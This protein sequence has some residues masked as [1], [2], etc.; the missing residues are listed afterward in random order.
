MARVGRVAGGNEVA[1]H[2]PHRRTNRRPGGDQTGPASADA[3]GTV[4]RSRTMS[5]MIVVA[6]EALIDLLIHP[7][8]RLAAV[9]GGAPFNTARTIARLGGAV[10]F[11][12]RLSSDR[13]GGVL[14]ERLASD[15]VDLSLAG[16]TDAP[17]TLAVAEL[18]GDGAA[19]YRFHTAETSAPGLTRETVRSAL[20]ARPAAFHLGTLGLVLEPMASALAAG[21]TGLG[22]ET[23]VMLDPNCRPAVIDRRD[24][25]LERLDAVLGRADVVKVSLEDLAYLAPGEAVSTAARALLER[26]PS[27]VLL[28]DGSRGVSIVTRGGAVAVPVP[29]VRV[30]DT[31]GAGDAFG[32]GFLARWIERGLGRSELAD[33]A[34]VRE[35]V[36]RAIE[37]ASLTCRRPGA[38]PPLRVEVDWPPA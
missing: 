11:L 12:G 9:P 31:V 3:T 10:A 28:T 1:H 33:E 37:V 21:V 14:R 32:G 35:A 23:L 22:D 29:A 2:E 7:D 36:T 16:T 27:V 18:D 13:F 25:Y 4:R 34:A 24:A 5:P 30:V 15:G 20:A 17:T 38:E 6:G 26:G 8:G 19:T